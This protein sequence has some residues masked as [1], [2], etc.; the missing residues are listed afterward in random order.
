MKADIFIRTWLPDLKWLAYCLRFLAKNWAGPGDIHVIANRD[1][2]DH[3]KQW[4]DQ[5]TFHYVDPWPDTH[6]FKCFCALL[7]PVLSDADL[8]LNIDSDHMLVERTVL[9]DFLYQGKPII[10]YR[11]HADMGDYLGIRLWTPPVT[12]WLGQAPTRSYMISTPFAFWRSTI[13]GLR[14]LIEQRSGRH[15]HE[16]LYSEVPFQ[17]QN[18]IQHPKRFP[19]WEVLGFYAQ[20][21]EPELYHFQDPGTCVPGYPEPGKSRWRTYHSWTAWNAQTIAEM[22]RLLL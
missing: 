13:S 10:Y 7:P 8:I 16:A 19:D 4:A 17:V 5:A 20:L 9:D 1:C 3:C 21:H 12:Y 2:Q 15:Y 6:E 22:D 11:E 18:F 14:K